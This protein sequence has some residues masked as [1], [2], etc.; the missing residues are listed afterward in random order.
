MKIAIIGDGNVGF[1]LARQLSKEGHD[2]VLID[3]DQDVLQHAQER[4]DVLVV[5]G[6]GATLE[7][8][9][10]ADIGNCDLMVAVTSSDETNLLCCIL[11]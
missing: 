5:V 10:E 7:V 6:N 8:Q 9:R 4:L 11:A 1:T 2:L 3:S